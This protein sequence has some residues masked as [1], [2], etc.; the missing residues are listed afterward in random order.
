MVV[1]I[2]WPDSCGNKGELFFV[3][4]TMSRLSSSLLSLHILYAVQCSVVVVLGSI[5]YMIKIILQEISTT[6]NYF[7]TTYSLQEFRATS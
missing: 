2:R 3:S 1:Y 6:T 7:L 5:G 4:T